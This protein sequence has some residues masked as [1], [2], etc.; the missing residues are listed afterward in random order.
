[1]RRAEQTGR[2]SIISMSL[3]GAGMSRAMDTAIQNAFNSGVLVVGKF[4][5][6]VLHRRFYIFISAR[7]ETSHTCIYSHHGCYGF[8]FQLSSLLY[9][10]ID[11]VVVFFFTLVAAGNEKQL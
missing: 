2:K 11:H 8:L 5:F 1:V 3:G 10:L 7:E 6:W 9:T 4:L